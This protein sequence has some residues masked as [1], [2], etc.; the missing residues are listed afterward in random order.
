MSKPK[1]SRLTTSNREYK[2]RKAE[3]HNVLYEYKKRH[4][5]NEL[6][7]AISSRVLAKST[8]PH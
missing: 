3:E 5:A 2:K 8:L 4:P 1:K 6:S 7:M